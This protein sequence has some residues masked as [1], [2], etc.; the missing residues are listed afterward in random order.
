MVKVRKTFFV[1]FF[2]FVF[3]CIF[4]FF[5]L[6]HKTKGAA[7]ERSLGGQLRELDASHN[8]LRQRNSARRRR[9]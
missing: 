7:D 9:S 5:F 8:D 6:V 1:F 4:F 3:F 2:L